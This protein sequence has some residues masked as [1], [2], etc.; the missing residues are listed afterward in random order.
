MRAERRVI[1]PLRVI[2]SALA[3]RSGDD[4]DSDLAEQLVGVASDVSEPLNRRR[5]RL[6]EK[7][8]LPERLPKDV[9][10][11]PRR[12]IATPERAA[13]SDRFA[14]VAGWFAPAHD[15]LV[16]I[17]EPGH[18][19]RIRVDIGRRNVDIGPRE[20]D[21]R[22]RVRPAQTLQFVL[23]EVVGRNA[24]APLAASVRQ[25]RRGALDGHPRRQGRHLFPGYVR[26]IPDA[27]LVRTE[28]VVVM[29]PPPLDDLNGS[30]V[31]LQRN[32]DFEDFL[33]LL[34]DVDVFLLDIQVRHRLVYLFQEHLK[35]IHLR[36]ASSLLPQFPPR[37]PARA[38]ST[39]ERF[40][41][42]SSLRSFH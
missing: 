28:R 32:G 5:Q 16:R 24:D 8:N 26:V 27:S 40:S 13:E 41:D 2:G 12:R 21:D 29:R 33:R 14:R 30:V 20:A 3:V 17:D 19:L 9:H 39:L 35:R 37:Q 25:H 11:A 4:G 42:T 18:D 1:E 34:E 36:H 6:S 10:S 23:R 31:Q 22:H 15:L 7:P 38:D